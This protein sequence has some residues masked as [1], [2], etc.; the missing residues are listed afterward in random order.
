MW[1]DNFEYL[2]TFYPKQV[3]E[4]VNRHYKNVIKAHGAHNIKNLS[5]QCFFSSCTVIVAQTILSRIINLLYFTV[6]LLLI[7]H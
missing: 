3:I 2:L 6:L 5:Y 7:I 1:Y 4:T